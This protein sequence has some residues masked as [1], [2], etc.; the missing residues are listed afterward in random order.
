MRARHKGEKYIKWGFE[1]PFEV[2]WAGL[3]GPISGG[4]EA[5][6]NGLDQSQDRM[7]IASRRALFG[8]LEVAAAQS[9]GQDNNNCCELREHWVIVG[10]LRRFF[11]IFFSYCRIVNLNLAH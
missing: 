1:L 8:E 5:L 6:K 11:C 9:L 7:M 3:D 4:Q 2:G 10:S